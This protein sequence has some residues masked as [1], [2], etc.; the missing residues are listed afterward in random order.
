M[1]IVDEPPSV[2]D[3]ATTDDCVGF[4]TWYTYDFPTRST[5]TGIEVSRFWPYF[6][7]KESVGRVY[8]K[9]CFAD[10]SSEVGRAVVGRLTCCRVPL[11]L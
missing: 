3:V 4:G 1:V 11:V 8:G 5:K 6:V 2:V 7:N 9:V 10:E